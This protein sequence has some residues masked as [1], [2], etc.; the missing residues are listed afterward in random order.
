MCLDSLILLTLLEGVWLFSLLEMVLFFVWSFSGACKLHLL[1]FLDGEMEKIQQI[2][3][4]IT[5]KLL[6]YSS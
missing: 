3:L 5:D 1:I 4:T 6:F 2:T